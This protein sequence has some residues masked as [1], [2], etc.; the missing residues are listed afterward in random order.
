MEE[1]KLCQFP[2][3]QRTPLDL[4]ALP[5]SMVGASPVGLHHVTLIDPGGLHLPQGQIQVKGKSSKTSSYFCFTGYS[6]Y[7]KRQLVA[8]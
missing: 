1:S 7:S 5:V 6:K 3:S 4:S 2:T 8:K